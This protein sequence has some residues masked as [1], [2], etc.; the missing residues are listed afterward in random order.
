[1]KKAGEKMAVNADTVISD[2]LREYGDIAPVM[3][4]LG[5]KKVGGYDVRRLIMRMITVRRAA[6]VHRVPLEEMIEKLQMAI[7]NVHAAR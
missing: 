3:E 7:D 2:V 4:S 5:M 6:I 1:M